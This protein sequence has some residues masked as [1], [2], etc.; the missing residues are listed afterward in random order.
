[1]SK[2]DPQY[3]VSSHDAIAA[4][5]GIRRRT[6]QDWLGAGCPG[7]VE[8][9]G[10][11]TKYNLRLVF[12]WWKENVYKPP[13]DPEELSHLEEL[14]RLQLQQKIRS[15]ELDYA[16]EKQDVIRWLHVQT[17]LERTAARYRQAGDLLRKHHGP[18]AQKI[19]HDAIDAVEAELDTMFGNTA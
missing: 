16:K 2:Y 4:F 7:T 14:K 8:E 12:G 17:Y 10:K 19:L 15:G 11:R 18:D 13:K 5:F 3:T 9:E 6:V 1:M